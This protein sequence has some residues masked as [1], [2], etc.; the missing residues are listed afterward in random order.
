MTK[1]LAGAWYRA[2]VF[3]KLLSFSSL[4]PKHSMN[5][6]LD[7]NR[8]FE[9]DPIAS[10]EPLC[11]GKLFQL[12]IELQRPSLPL[13]KLGLQVFEPILNVPCSTPSHSKSST[14]DLELTLRAVRPSPPVINAG[15]AAVGYV[16][17]TS[18]EKCRAD[19]QRS[20]SR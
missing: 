16:D 19:L 2:N 13:F 6:I 12:L 20:R 9:N 8:R 17:L 5:V 7:R 14:R 3:W 10:I 11:P 18:N 4:A 15:P 1:Y